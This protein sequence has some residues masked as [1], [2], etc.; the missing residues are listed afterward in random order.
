LRRV[1]TPRGEYD[2]LTLRAG[3]RVTFASNYFHN[4]WHILAGCVGATA[5]ARLLW[6]VSFDR[7]ENVV[8]LLDGEHIVQNPFDGMRTRPILLCDSERTFVD[9]SVVSAILVMRAQNKPSEKTVGLQSQGLAYAETTDAL[10]DRLGAKRQRSPLH[11]RS[12]DKLWRREIAKIC[13]G[14]LV[15]GAPALILRERA[16]SVASMAHSLW[17][18]MGLSAGRSNY[19]SIAH[20]KG[21]RS[22]DGEVQIFSKFEEL[23]AAANG[24][25]ALRDDVNGFATAVERAYRQ[26]TAQRK[27]RRAARQRRDDL[28]FDEA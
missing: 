15:Y 26:R 22:P 18:T 19:L 11:Y 9:D 27:P 23:V 1:A 4:T 8:V 3:M 7:R 13:S 16:K 20:R 6:A 24:V 12:S 2:V 14:A 5:L 17:P 10:T 21:E 25:D 28:E